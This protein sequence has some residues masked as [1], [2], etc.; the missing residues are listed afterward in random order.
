[1]ALSIAVRRLAVPFCFAVALPA[2]LTAQ[3]TV[4]LLPETDRAFDEYVK[5]AESEMDGRPRFE[6]SGIAISV[7]AGGLRSS[8]DVKDGIVH[9]WAA[10]AVAPGATVDKALGVLQSYEDY[11]KVYAPDITAA[12]LLSSEGGHS[13]IQVQVRKKKI[14]TVILDTEYDVEVR[15]LEDGKKAVFSRST[16]ISEVDNGRPL[17]PGTGHGFAWR[18]NTYWLLAPRPEGVYLECRIITLSRDVPAALAWAIKPMITSVP[19]ES[20]RTTLEATIRALR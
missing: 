8:I 14:V 1:V 15:S 11:K 17:P 10:A 18:A 7:A 5:A 9:D 16:R 6:T 19:R 4:H 13:H 2:S 3:F 12:K 20:L